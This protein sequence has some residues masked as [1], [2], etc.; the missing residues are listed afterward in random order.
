MKRKNIIALK[1]CEQKRHDCYSCD[2]NGRCHALNNTHFER[3]GYTYKCP[4]FKTRLQ[5]Y[6]ER[7]KNE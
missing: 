4:F 5:V 2:E 6:M 3:D 7:Q 1:K